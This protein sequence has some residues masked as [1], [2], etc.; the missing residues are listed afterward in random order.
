MWKA[1]WR[2]FGS[3]SER[4]DEQEEI[5]SGN[6]LGVTSYPSEGLVCSEVQMRKEFLIW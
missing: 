4:L 5:T 3:L 6:I 1:V 2:T